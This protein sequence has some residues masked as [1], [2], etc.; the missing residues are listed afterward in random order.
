MKSCRPQR[1]K[2]LSPVKWGSQ[3]WRVP[4]G[5]W[6]LHPFSMWWMDLYLYLYLI[7]IS[8]SI[9]ISYVYIYILCVYKYIHVCRC[10]FILD[11]IPCWRLTLWRSKKAMATRRCK[12]SGQETRGTGYGDCLSAGGAGVPQQKCRPFFRPGVGIDVPF[13]GILN[14]NCWVMFNWDI[15]QPLLYFLFNLNPILYSMDVIFCGISMN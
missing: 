3:R 9:S 6:C 7:S 14:I 11:I 15:Y 10:L 8:L 1:P 4:W 12:A 13:M 2:A 5:R